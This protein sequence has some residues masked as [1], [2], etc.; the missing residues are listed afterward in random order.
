MMLRTCE[1]I[2]VTEE[3]VGRLS[4]CLLL[5]TEFL[6]FHF[7]RPQHSISIASL[8]LAI[9]GL[10]LLFFLINFKVCVLCAVSEYRHSRALACVWRS[11]AASGAGPAFLLPVMGPD[12]WCFLL[13]CIPA[14]WLGMLLLP[15]WP[16]SRRALWLASLYLALRVLGDSNSDP[17]T[18][19]PSVLSTELLICSSGEHFFSHT[20]DIKMY[21]FKTFACLNT[22][23][24]IIIELFSL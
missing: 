19:V 13:S 22:R 14:S 18:C 6:P 7:P 20:L 24:F 12:L 15:P 3:N 16:Q 23:P 1:N 21:L 9:S 8:K 4:N 17:Q 2:R 10:S 5:S 11:K